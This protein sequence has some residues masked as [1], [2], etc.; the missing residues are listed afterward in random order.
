LWG[1]L[2]AKAIEDALELP[3]G[4]SSASSKGPPASLRGRQD[5][6]NSAAELGGRGH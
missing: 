5:Q 3:A 4:S 6:S 2:F 1:A